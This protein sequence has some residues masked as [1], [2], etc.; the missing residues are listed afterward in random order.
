MTWEISSRG[1]LSLFSHTI[2][3]FPS[4]PRK[5]LNFQMG[6]KHLEHERSGWGMQ[7]CYS[8]PLDFW[9]GDLVQCLWRQK[10]IQLLNIIFPKLTPTSDKTM[11]RTTLHSFFKLEQ[12][13]LIKTLYIFWEISEMTTLR[14]TNMMTNLSDNNVNLYLWPPSPSYTLSSV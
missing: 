5:V 4:T 12:A 3:A 9:K 7:L 6:G 13:G 14:M 8:F 2:F 10:R 1:T 11:Y